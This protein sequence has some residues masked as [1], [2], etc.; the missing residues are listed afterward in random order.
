MSAVAIKSF[1]ATKLC[2]PACWKVKRGFPV[3]RYILMEEGGEN[4][5][6]SSVM[7]YS[8]DTVLFSDAPLAH[9]SDIVFDPV[10]LTVIGCHR[11]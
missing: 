8:F 6:A 7:L 10:S 2:P 3:V 9:S 11:L 4:G 5:L 1:D